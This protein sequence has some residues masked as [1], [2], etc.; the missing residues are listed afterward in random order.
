MDRCAEVLQRCVPPQ[1]N[2][3]SRNRR[4]IFT[5]IIPAEWTLSLAIRHRGEFIG[6]IDLRRRR[7]PRSTSSDVEALPGLLRDL[8]LK[9]GDSYG[10]TGSYILRPFQGH[11][12]GTQAR[13][14][15]LTVALKYC[16]F[17]IT[18]SESWPTNV[19]SQA[20]SLSCGYTFLGTN[21]VG[22]NRVGN[23]GVG[24]EAQ[25]CECIAPQTCSIVGP[26][27]CTSTGGLR[28]WPRC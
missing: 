24:N 14:A 19:A 9:A 5:R 8:G 11:G 13:R 23:N 4:P 21:H 22:T 17:G 15:A 2:G 1:L 26:P 28:N 6:V 27:R 16:G 18:V 20:V 12:Y 7:I 25:W 10:E 3:K